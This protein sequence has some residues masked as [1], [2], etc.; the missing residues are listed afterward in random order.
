[1]S[2]ELTSKSVAPRSSDRWNSELIIQTLENLHRKNKPI[3][4]RQIR[5]SNPALF[6]AAIHW[7][8]S[9]RNA[10]EAAGI[11]YRSIQKSVP[12][13]WNTHTVRRELRRLH[14][15]KTPLHHA[16]LERENPALVLAAYRYFGSYGSA[17][18]AAGLK[19]DRIR[20]RPMPSWD[21]KR[22][23]GRIK[24]LE[25]NK[26]GLWKRAVRRVDP[27]LDR[28]ADR[29]FGSYK[30]A[31]RLSGVP[32]DLLQPPPYRFWSPEKIVDDLKRTYQQNPRLLKPARLVGKKGRLLRACRRRFGSY[33][34]ALHAAGISYGEV[35]M[36][37]A[38]TAAEI[39]AK[40]TELFERGKDLR[41][42]HL[43]DSNRRLLEASRRCFGSF[44]KAVLA[45]GLDYPP[46]PPM[47]H[48]TATLVLKTL[49]DLHRRHV[50][51]RYRQFRKARLPLFEAA[52]HYFGTY[53]GA[54]KLAGI[55]YSDMV[56]EQLS[57]ELPARKRSHQES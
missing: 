45:A 32:L 26:T 50:D 2:R 3:W 15:D 39:I 11:E 34:R 6:A 54:I 29:C 23:I 1:M 17:I 33:R 16:A 18:A 9:Y 47:R 49:K 4:S 20:I 37:P 27:Y 7:F 41:Y 14:R 22:V 44:E 12:G 43:R 10:I 25:K 57:K 35:V 38:M 8:G 24:E 48:W 40:L 21:K 51:L 31:A 19:Y 56:G 42:S 55:D 30:R 28:A 52:R 36:P 46:A 53:L 13:R 5:E